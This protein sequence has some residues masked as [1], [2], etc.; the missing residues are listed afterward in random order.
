[1]RY[2]DFLRT[3]ILLFAASATVLGAAALI[4]AHSHDDLTLLYVA[5]GV[6]AAGAIYGGWLGRRA[7]A[8]EGIA[9]LLAS[10]RTTP[11]LP[12]LQPGTILFG[13]LWGLAVFTAVSVAV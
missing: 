12:E 3:S 9:R 7:A 2:S 6:W 13:R 1:M 10:A 4:G 5:L 11:L 8:T